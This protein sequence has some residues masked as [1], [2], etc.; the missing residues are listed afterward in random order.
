MYFLQYL[1]DLKKVFEENNKEKGWKLWL[2]DDEKYLKELGENVYCI[3]L[4]ENTDKNKTN[5]ID[6]KFYYMATK[7]DDEIEG[8]M[9]GISDFKK[10]S[11]E[12]LTDIEV[13]LINCKIN[14][15]AMKE[16]DDLRIAELDFS[17][18]ITALYDVSL[19]EEI[20]QVMGKLYLN[21]NGIKTEKLEE[22]NE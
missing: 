7:I 17:I 9:V 8:F 3:I 14:Y 21:L 22:I 6:I 10:L 13:P 15:C 18:D 4:G 1:N 2:I 12:Y 5:I 16:R 19:D 11:I 20:D